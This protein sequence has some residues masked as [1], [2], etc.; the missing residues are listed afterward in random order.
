M[1]PL[2]VEMKERQTQETEA[3]LETM[4]HLKSKLFSQPRM[5]RMVFSMLILPSKVSHNFIGV[6]EA[7]RLGIVFKL[8]NGTIRVVDSQAKPI[9]G[10]TDNVKVKMA[11]GKLS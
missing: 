5:K 9:I 8:A 4:Q 10:S 11:I 1:N 7:R 3:D 2:V 6:Q